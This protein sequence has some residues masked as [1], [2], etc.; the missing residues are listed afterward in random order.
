MNLLNK[1]FFFFEFEQFFVVSLT[2]V[3]ILGSLLDSLVEVIG[4]INWGQKE[5]DH[6][7]HLVSELI[8]I[9]IHRFAFFRIGNIYFISF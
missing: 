9:F 4:Q 3:L 8:C 5:N 1:S 6:G 7:N 2:E